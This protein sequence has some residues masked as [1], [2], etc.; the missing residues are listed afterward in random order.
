MIGGFYEVQFDIGPMLRDNRLSIAQFRNGTQT[1]Q[2]GQISVIIVYTSNVPVTVFVPIDGTNYEFFDAT[3]SFITT[4]EI[5]TQDPQI[6]IIYDAGEQYIHEN[7][8]DPEA[9]LSDFEPLGD[10][11]F[12]EIDLWIPEEPNM[13]ITRHYSL[14]QFNTLTQST[15]LSL[16]WC[17]GDSLP[18]SVNAT[19][20]FSV[21]I[22]Y[23][24]YIKVTGTTAV[25]DPDVTELI[26][27]DRTVTVSTYG[28]IDDA[29]LFELQWTGST[30]AM[31]NQ[32]DMFFF[33]AE[34]LVNAWTPS[35]GSFYAIFYDIETF[36]LATETV[37]FNITCVSLP[38]TPAPTTSAPTTSAPTTPTPT[39]DV[40]T[41]PAP[42][43]P[44]PTTS[45]PTT[46]A[47]TPSAPTTPTP[48]TPTPTTAAPTT[49]LPDP[50]TAL[51]TTSSDTS[52]NPGPTLSPGAIA[53][54]VVA[55]V[56]VV[57][58]VVALATYFAMQPK[59]PISL[60]FRR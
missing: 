19:F 5:L 36:V 33:Y 32:T 51:P 17:P 48:T 21:P 60:L 12:A 46:S 11:P 57:A 3:F 10:L 9:L 37:Y 44:T 30:Q 15:S 26:P 40:P 2:V 38:T 41:T 50:T 58:G 25:G 31:K 43:T 20:G 6:T 22:S 49:T 7:P 14:S 34:R 45:A 39:T 13:I 54:I 16:T 8:G 28:L 42:T 4:Y 53:G 23:S 55:N 56:V 35:N 47:P 52:S 59:A 29:H 27:Y 18:D 24:T 1:I